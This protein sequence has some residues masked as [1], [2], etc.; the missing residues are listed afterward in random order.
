M[1]PPRRSF[2]MNKRAGVTKQYPVPAGT[3]NAK[4]RTDGPTQPEVNF[5][6]D[7]SNSHPRFGGVWVHSGST[8][9]S[10]E[11][12]VLVG[13]SY[14]MQSFGAQGGRRDAPGTMQ[15]GVAS[16]PTLDGSSTKMAEMGQLYNQVQAADKQ[17][18]EK[19]TVRVIIKNGN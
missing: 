11:G 10:T 9:Q 3:Y 5:K 12:C 2:N 7:T 19:T 14:H 6:L 8:P 1:E 16:Y 15:P 13:S 18:G 4:G 17:D